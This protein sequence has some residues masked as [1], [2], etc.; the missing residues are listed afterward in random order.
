MRK[1]L[2]EL[3]SSTASS[4]HTSHSSIQ[5]LATEQIQQVKGG[6]GYDTRPKSGSSVAI[7]NGRIVYTVGGNSY[8]FS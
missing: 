6:G 8:Y 7:V 4:T 5:P 3:T 1:L 2:Q